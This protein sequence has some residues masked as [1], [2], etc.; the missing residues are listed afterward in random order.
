MSYTESLELGMRL[1]WRVLPELSLVCVGVTGRVTAESLIHLL[2]C[3]RTDPEFRAEMDRLYVI[4]D[5]AN[6]T[7]VSYEGAIAVKRAAAALAAGDTWQNPSATFYRVAMVCRREL[8]RPLMQLYEAMWS[9]EKAPV[10]EARMFETVPKALAWFETPPEAVP[11][12]EAVVRETS[13]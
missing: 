11:L 4:G 5:D 12:V 8:N 2:Q 10:L 3:L 6:F 13:F 1:R 7:C 9:G